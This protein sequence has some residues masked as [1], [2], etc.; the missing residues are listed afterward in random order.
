MIGDTGASPPCI[1]YPTPLVINLRVP[2]AGLQEDQ[3][4]TFNHLTAPSGFSRL[5]CEINQV[6]ILLSTEHTSTSPPAIEDFRSLWTPWDECIKDVGAA[7]FAIL[8][9]RCFE[10][11]KAIL[12]AQGATLDLAAPETP[13]D[14]CI[15]RPLTVFLVDHSATIDLVGRL[16]DHSAALEQRYFL[17]RQDVNALRDNVAHLMEAA[18][19]RDNSSKRP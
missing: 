9:R 15:Y 11:T 17:L 8:D 14:A 5:E 18:A 12:L 1:E 4:K 2:V 16:F 19:Q 3:H 6:V 13:E 7:F 10:E